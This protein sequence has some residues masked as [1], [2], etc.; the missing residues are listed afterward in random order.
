VLAEE[1]VEDRRVSQPRPGGP[2]PT[3]IGGVRMKSLVGFAVLFGVLSPLRLSGQASAPGA[4]AA[5]RP[6]GFTEWQPSQRIA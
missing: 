5:E 2:P 4:V 1:A 6:A 3:T